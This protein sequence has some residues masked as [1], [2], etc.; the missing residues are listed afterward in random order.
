MNKSIND[1]SWVISAAIL[2]TIYFFLIKEYTRSNNN[3]L[4]LILIILQLTVMYLYYKS[5]QKLHSGILYAVINGL[6][7]IFGSLIANYYFK[8][9]FTKYDIIG[10]LLI[11]I[12][13]LIV[14]K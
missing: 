3:N 5:L 6:S 10:I 11:V 14:G 1:I 7:V 13:I 4:F 2:S 8:E 12:G 9:T